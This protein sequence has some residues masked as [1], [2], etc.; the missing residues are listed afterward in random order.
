MKK[1]HPKD[2]LSI[3]EFIKLRMEVVEM[4]GVAESGIEEGDDDAPPGDDDAPPGVEIA[5]PGLEAPSNK[6]AASSKVRC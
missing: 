3:D 2:I 6:R 5:P 1:H 4:L